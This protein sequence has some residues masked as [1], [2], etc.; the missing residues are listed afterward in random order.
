MSRFL[1]LQ[2]SGTLGSGST[3][4]WRATLKH[5]STHF[6]DLDHLLHEISEVA[7]WPKVCN[8]GLVVSL[9]LVGRFEDLA[10]KVD[11]ATILSF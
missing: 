4:G 11:K 9:P 3:P 8:C 2:T 10:E 5:Q 6:D 1:L 7:N